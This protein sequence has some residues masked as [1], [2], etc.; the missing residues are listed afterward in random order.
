MAILYVESMFA[1]P[2]GGAAV[3]MS[4]PMGKLLNMSPT[5]V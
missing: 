4:E 3:R 5:M 1:L 2:N